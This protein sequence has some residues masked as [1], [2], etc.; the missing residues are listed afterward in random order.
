M[1]ENA[2]SPHGTVCHVEFN[3]PDL[4]AAQT[5]YA[6]LFGWTFQP[7]GPE[8]V[9]FTAG[10]GPCG[11]IYAGPPA[12]CATNRIYVTVDDIAATIAKGAEHGVEV[13]KDKT[14]IGDDFG[15]YAHLRMPDGNLI[16]IWSKA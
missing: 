10:A 16:G 7:M 13:E 4:G 12:T 14:A 1:T 8:T 6:A 11:C 15:Y 2:P 9:Y 3:A 5:W